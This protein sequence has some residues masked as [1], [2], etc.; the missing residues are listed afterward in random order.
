MDALLPADPDRIGPY[1]LEGRL[2]AGGMGEVFLGR[3]PGGRRVAVKVIRPTYAA[4][5]RFRARFARELEAAR[6]VGG[7]HTAQVIDSDPEAESPWLATAYIPGRSLHAVVMSDGPLGT[8]EVGALGAGLA[9][10]LAAIHACGIVHRDVKPSNVIMSDDGPRIIDFGI[11]RPVGAS[12]LTSAGVVIG[13]FAFMSP[14]QVR[15]ERTDAASDVFSL[16]AVLAFATTGRGPFDAETI[17]AIVHRIVNEE[18]DL[19]GLSGPLRDTIEACLA[20]APAD[21]PDVERLVA[22][23]AP[24]TWRRP[25]APSPTALERP[26]PRAPLALQDLSTVTAARNM[27]P[28][29]D[30]S[31][32]DRDR[33]SRRKVLGLAGGA[34]VL[35]GGGV[36]AATRLTGEAKDTAKPPTPLAEVTAAV[37]LWQ[38]SGPLNLTSVTAHSDGVVCMGSESVGIE[39]HTVLWNVDA[40]GRTAWELP[41]PKFPVIRADGIRAGA[42]HQGVFY[43]GASGLADDNG[44]K[45]VPTQIVAVDLAHGTQSWS[46]KLTDSECYVDSVSGPRNGMLYATGTTTA[47]RPRPVV[48]VVDIASRQRARAV[49]AVYEKKNPEADG[50]STLVVPASGDRVFHL[51]ST[52]GS[53]QEAQLQA[54]DTAHGYVP[55]WKVTVPEALGDVSDQPC[56]CAAGDVLVYAST[57]LI[58]LDPASGDRLWTNERPSGSYDGFSTPAASTDGSLVYVAH[59]TEETTGSG[60]RIAV[61]TLQALHPKSGKQKWSS[62]VSVPIDSTENL[63]DQPAVLVDGSVAY[64]LVGQFVRREFDDMSYIDA[65]AGRAQHP[66]VWAV[67]AVSGASRWKHVPPESFTA[68]A[69]SGRLYVATPAGVVALSATM[70]H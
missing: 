37:P 64:V 36:L 57:S 59:H 42:V 20:K 48:W 70:A 9:E 24:S 21:R 14:E 65:G 11:A 30:S 39:N 41:L 40:A 17:P 18:P 31:A 49:E 28:S 34:L 33:P 38:G 16:G 44:V 66:L 69:H 13:T 35:A 10:G 46:V 63:G 4:D 12:S 50:S 27:A 62:S 8:D 32:P 25:D 29:G 47:R 15:A 3:S 43:F 68:S 67:D 58:G 26:A 2:G 6:Q 52:R 53:G 7:F 23:L 55:A 19:G 5:A 22:M 1:R 45:N 54:F 61:L 60:Q 51:A 56:A